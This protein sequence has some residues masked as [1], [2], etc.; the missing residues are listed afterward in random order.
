MKNLVLTLATKDAVIGIIHLIAA[1][2]FFITTSKAALS[3]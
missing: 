2:S 1:I 3:F